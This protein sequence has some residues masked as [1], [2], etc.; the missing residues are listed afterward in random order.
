VPAVVIVEDHLLL[1][2]ILRATLAARGITAGIAAPAPMASLAATVRA[3]EP[4]VVLLDLDLGAHGDSTALIAPLA[5]DG[6]RVVVMSG[7]T[8]RERLALAFEAGAAGFHAKAVGLEPLIAKTRAALAGHDL[9]APLRHGL[10]TDLARIRTARAVALAPFR[11][12][13]ERERDTLIALCSGLAVQRIATEWVVSEA[14][15]RSHVRNVLVKLGVSSQ[16]G[17]V[18]LA[19]RSGWLAA[20]AA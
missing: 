17:A 14:T 20:R 1:A 16:L 3:A 5:A 8:D 4:A 18:A 2:E 11:Q 15:V 12:L 6:I 19:L 9:D 7:T 10:R 13:T